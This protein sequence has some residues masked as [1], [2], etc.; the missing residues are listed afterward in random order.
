MAHPAQQAFTAAVKA[1]HPGHFQSGRALD[2]GA[3]D[4]NGSNRTLFAHAVE[5][6]G[7]DLGPGKGVDIVAHGADFR[8]ELWDGEGFSVV[9]ST[10]ALEHD[11]RWE[12][13]FR[14]MYEMTAKGG[15]MVMTC[16]G[17]GRPEH[18][19]K[20]TSPQNSPHTTDYYRNLA[21]EDFAHLL[22]GMKFKE[23][24]WEENGKPVYD[25]YFW[26][27]KK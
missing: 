9:I 23:S 27:I 26:G 21:P 2:I 11:S 14:A 15:L 24:A 18:G 19:T 4:I 20:R 17:T 10:E 25:T 22:K 5:Y 1:K 7:I 12:E 13:T 8:A 3:Q 6:L 16:A